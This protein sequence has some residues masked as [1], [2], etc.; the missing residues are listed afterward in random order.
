MVIFNSNVKLPEGRLRQTLWFTRLT[1]F[2]SLC[3]LEKLRVI[4]VVR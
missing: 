4:V 2:D 3:E 1:D